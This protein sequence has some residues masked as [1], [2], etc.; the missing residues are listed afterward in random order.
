MP[1]QQQKTAVPVTNGHP[2]AQHA[3][4][5]GLSLPAPTPL[6]WQ[7]EKSDMPDEAHNET[8]SA[9]PTV[10][11]FALPYQ[12]AAITVTDAAHGSFPQPWHTAALPARSTPSQ[13][14]L[15]RF[16]LQLK[17]AAPV[18]AKGKV[19]QLTSAQIR[20]TPGKEIKDIIIRG[21][22]PR[23]YSDSMGDHTTAFIVQVEG[24]NIALQG[25]SVEEALAYMRGLSDH[26]NDLPGVKFLNESS[27]IA[28]RFNNERDTLRSSLAA[29]D[30]AGKDGNI[31]LLISHLQQA[32]AAYLDARELVPFST[33]NVGVKS[34]GTAGRGHGETRGAKIL[35]AFER[36]KEIITD[37]TLLEAVFGLFDDRSAGQVAVE[38]NVTT[39]QAL[40]GGGVDAAKLG[41]EGVVE[42]KIGFIKVIWEQH[43]KSIE[44]LFPRVYAK[45]GAQ[46]AGDFFENLKKIKQQN[47]RNLIHDVR[48]ALN[49]ARNGATS[50]E[51]E[52]FLWGENIKLSILKLITSTYNEQR[53]AMELMKE[54]YPLNKELGNE[55]SG[56]I[57]DLHKE[58]E[59]VNKLVAERVPQYKEGKDVI[60]NA[61]NAALKQY[62]GQRNEGVL[63]AN[64]RSALTGIKDYQGNNPFNAFTPEKVEQPEKAKAG[65]SGRPEK[66][67]KEDEKPREKAP[68][69]KTLGSQ[70][71]PM[72]IQ[73]ILD[74]KGDIRQML[75]SG[76]PPSPFTKTM[77]AHTTAWVV[78]LDRIRARIIGK[79]IAA[80][81]TALKEM[82]KEVLTFDEDRKR[83]PKGSNV[84]YVRPAA[85]KNIKANEKV[86]PENANI[87]TI[88]EMI[89]AILTFFNLI[90]GVTVD[91]IDTTGHGEG[92]YRKVLLLFEK[93]GRGAS[94]ATITEAI[95]GLRDGG[96]P[97]LHEGYI[98]EAYPKSYQ[99][100]TNKRMVDQR[101]EK[102]EDNELDRF[103]A[104]TEPEEEEAAV[105][106]PK[107]TME[108]EAK[109]DDAAWLTHVNNCLI[110]AIT[111]AAGV[112]RADGDTIIRIRKRL[113]APVGE[114]LAAS[115]ANLD[116]ILEVLGL[117]GW[118]VVVVYEGDTYV[119]ESSNADSAPPLFIYHDGINHF[120]KLY[121]P[122]RIEKDA[123]KKHDVG[124]SVAAIEEE[125]DD[126]DGTDISD[127]EEE[128]TDAAKSV[129]I[130]KRHTEE[131]KSKRPSKT[132]KALPELVEGIS[133]LPSSRGGPG[134]AFSPPPS[135]APA[136]SSDTTTAPQEMDESIDVEEEKGSDTPTAMNLEDTP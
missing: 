17:P 99:Y 23:V 55:F 83:M 42:E 124:T 3:G 35:S 108:L 49:K 21:R 103:T 135:L 66:E 95:N 98:K 1:D 64:A 128:E 19:A 57:E 65:T 27:M 63:T 82:S 70:L 87:S 43:K 18:T 62:T 4:D 20:L 73:I 120:T 50:I 75:S 123:D 96:N 13:S 56:Q 12:P 80:A 130:K 36:G 92:K 45:I 40:T 52:K 88:Q 11:R 90:P 121:T 86:V 102:I 127:R 113:G 33:V 29:A 15:Q 39:F 28:S 110:N 61:I 37:K 58:F 44:R 31:N 48:A 47:I 38:K 32:I 7:E 97:T 51:K 67:K 115:T 69:V 79:D 76:R 84:P 26:L 91:K 100:V 68:G 101:D 131:G 134:F 2:I 53:T 118:G 107:E 81:A 34:K 72:A 112:P 129:N 74:E 16:S 93:H 22:P 94:K 133:A 9:L 14:S 59:D 114:M 6:Q 71:N 89:S 5:K 132:R 125:D 117:D 119:D 60:D 8:A 25:K 122:E 78:H 24:I 10:Q 111:D 116:I 41:K 54:V 46:L 126:D 104:E 77:G 109:K 105:L 106:S 30:A 85:E 136:S